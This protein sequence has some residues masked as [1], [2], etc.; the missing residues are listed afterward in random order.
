MSQR[1]SRFWQY[2]IVLLENIVELRW[3]VSDLSNDW[4]P[5]ISPIKIIPRLLF[6]LELPQILISS[7]I[8]YLFFFTIKSYFANTKYKFSIWFLC[9]N[10][11]LFLVFIIVFGEFRNTR[12]EFSACFR[13][14][15]NVLKKKLNNVAYSTC[16]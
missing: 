13:L 10:L 15:L 9:K 7:N 5:M 2:F 14:I 1:I 4:L 6:W 8:I 16:G 12:N 11:F 3:C